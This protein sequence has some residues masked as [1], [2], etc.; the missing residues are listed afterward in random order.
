[1]V[2]LTRIRRWTILMVIDDLAEA[3]EEQMIAVLARARFCE[4]A[5]RRLNASPD[6]AFMAGVV[7][8]VAALL[9]MTRSV[10]AAQ[11]PLSAEM[12]AALVRGVGPLGRVLQIVDA[13]DD[14]ELLDAGLAVHYMDAVR[15]STRAVRETAYAQV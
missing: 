2:G 5:A 10:M 1:M 3:T 4:N 11:L 12:S 8:G 14:G 13:Y 15:W 6:A 9:G 7:S